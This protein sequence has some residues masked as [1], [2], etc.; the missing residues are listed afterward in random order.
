MKKISQ[1]ALN[2][3][4][5]GGTVLLASENKPRIVRTP[6]N[7]IIKIF[8]SKRRKRHAQKFRKNVHRLQRRGF[9]S[10]EQCQAAQCKQDHSALVIYPYQ[11]GDSAY[12]LICQQQK[13][14]LNDVADFMRRLHCAG[15]YFRDCHAG[16]LL[17]EGPSNFRMIDVHNTRFRL[18]KLGT[19]QRAKNL[20][21]F[22]YRRNLLE[23]IDETDINQFIQHYIECEAFPPQR[24][25]RFMRHWDK[26]ASQRRR[27]Y[28]A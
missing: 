11:S 16:N 14:V 27:K 23:H 10:V 19:R 18:G 20:A 24:Q 28:F 7:Q 1:Q 3:L 5:A 12:Q 13:N 17:R 6:N 9:S 2:E 22:I 26:Y 4:I 8:R 25:R 15:V 21:S